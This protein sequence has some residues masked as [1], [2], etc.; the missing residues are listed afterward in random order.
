MIGLGLKIL[1]YLLKYVDFNF[2]VKIV[3]QLKYMDKIYNYV[4][5]ENELDIE[6]K[7]LKDEMVVIKNENIVL[8]DQ[9]VTLNDEVSKLMKKGGK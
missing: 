8:K 7:A 6:V 3:P 4:V 2:L 1:P 9:I 5:D